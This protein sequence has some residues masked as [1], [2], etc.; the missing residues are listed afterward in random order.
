MSTITQEMTPLSPLG[1]LVEAV[2]Q[3]ERWVLAIGIGL[4]LAVM[5]FMTAKGTWI[6][7]LCGGLQMLG[8][9]VSDPHGVDGGR[10]GDR[11][12]GL[13]LLDLVTVMGRD[14]VLLQRRLK[15]RTRLGAFE[16]SGYEIHH[17]RSQAGG[18]VR[19]EA[20]GPQRQPLLYSDGGGVWGSYLHGLL[21]QGGFRQAFL[22][23]A[24]Q[25]QGRRFR[26]S[27]GSLAADREAS[28][29]AWA[30]HLRRHLDLRWL[31]SAPTPRRAR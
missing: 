18:G 14:K 27:P 13:G 16:L 21:D 1:K 19:V 20:R 7:G 11:V 30:A 4:Q 5:L 8:G 2:K 9:S 6:L 24:A 10:A 25:A 15:A 29:Q 26:G 23:A 17:G 12:Q 3:R 22:A 31:P 28:L